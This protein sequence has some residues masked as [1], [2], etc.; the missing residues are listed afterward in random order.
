[1]PLQCSLDDGVRPYLRG[2]KKCIHNHIF[3]LK[4]S[5]V[6]LRFFFFV[7]KVVMV[8]L[9]NKVLKCMVGLLK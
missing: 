5:N 1:M 8:D 3:S 2:E 9:V 7:S 6:K 4:F